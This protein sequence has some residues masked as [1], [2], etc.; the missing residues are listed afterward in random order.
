MHV[1]W[2]GH[3]ASSVTWEDYY[4]LKQRLPDAAAWGQA[5]YSS[6]GEVSRRTQE[7]ETEAVGIQK[8]AMAVVLCTATEP[9]V[10]LGG[11]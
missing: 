10:G 3:P 4:V 2:T 11:L 6:K 7:A 1:T 5:T 8:K 9:T